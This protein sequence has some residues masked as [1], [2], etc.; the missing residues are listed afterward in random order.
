MADEDLQQCAQ[1]AER[2]WRLAYALMR[3]AHDAEDVV[4]ES[5]VVAARRRDRIPTDDPWPWF[6][7]VVTNVV[8]NAR[9]SRRKHMHDE[10][11]DV[12][13]PTR[14]AEVSVLVAEALAQ[15]PEP[16][17]DAL[18]CTHLSGLTQAQAA[19]AL[20][21]PKGTVATRVRS[22]L[23]KLREKLGED[24]KKVVYGIGIMF[25][26]GPEGGIEVSTQRWLNAAQTRAATS[27]T[28]ANMSKQFIVAG[29]VLVVIGLAVWL[30][31]KDDRV[32]ASN[33]GQCTGVIADKEPN[34][35]RTKK[36]SDSLNP[37]EISEE[38]PMGGGPT[39]DPNESMDESATPSSDNLV[40]ADTLRFAEYAWP[41]T[42]DPHESGSVIGSR[43]CGMLYEGL[44][45]TDPFTPT[46]LRPCIAESLPVWSDKEQTWTFRLRDDVV[47]HDDP[48][49]VTSDNLNG[50]GRAATAS[51]VVWSI[52]R[53]SLCDSYWQL[54]GQIEGLD[55]FR[56][57]GVDKHGEDLLSYMYTK[58]SGLSAP[59][60]RTVVIKVARDDSTFLYALA[61]VAT[62]VVPHEA[63]ASYGEE[64]AFHPVGTGPYVIE[65]QLWNRRLDYIANPGYREVRLANVPEGSPVKRLEGRRLPLTKRV[66]Y[67]FGYT[68]EELVESVRKRGFVESP[69]QADA[70]RELLGEDAELTPGLHE[71]EDGLALDVRAEPTVGYW[72]FNMDDDLIGK[73]DKARAM[74]TALALG[75]DR[76]AYV[77]EVMAGL[78]VPADGLI[79]QNVSEQDC[80]VANQTFDAGRARDVLRQAGFELTEHSTGW[81]AIDPETA[82]QPEL[83]LVTRNLSVKEA[84][85]QVVRQLSAS[86]GIAIRIEPCSFSEFLERQDN[87]DGHIFDC[88]WVMDF[89]AP[90]NIYGLWKTG[91]LSLGFSDEEYDAAVV[92]IGDLR[93]G[94]VATRR[95]GEAAWK[96]VHKVL[97][98]EVPF[99]A[100]QFRLVVKLCRQGYIKP[101][102]PVSFGTSAKYCAIAK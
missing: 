41:R 90:E 59:D 82:R 96:T 31:Q 28:G 20:E 98:R 83:V 56:R 42:L 54:E 52:K 75:F 38:S 37:P 2:A 17:R 85:R 99:V 84:F 26:P 32:T 86:T 11:R 68:V 92:G 51:D 61:G 4:Q 77:R 8:R 21:V 7:T 102:A 5:F 16:E 15:L 91:R 10:P 35:T 19:E 63:V 14:D 95:R 6:A 60:G 53:M 9:R 72:S 24:E 78:G 97:G 101:D 93:S 55:E 44:L 58:V 67:E 65:T 23:A 64:F 50:E 39:A 62:A 25:I 46:V 100:I 29:A 12:P 70:W 71:L 43:Q 66:V 48:C 45:E 27:N 1:C 13:A 73:G 49:F 79:P 40:L 76:S 47:F 3:N 89:P 30:S 34:D 81:T 80:R 22:G 88:G 74:R 36:T 57:G 33:D 69:L 87:R 94:D 18:A